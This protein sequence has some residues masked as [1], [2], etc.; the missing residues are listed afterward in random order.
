MQTVWVWGLTLVLC[1]SCSTQ[2]TLASILLQASETGCVDSGGVCVPQGSYC[3]EV[4]STQNDDCV[5]GSICCSVAPKLKRD[6]RDTTVNSGKQM[7]KKRRKHK[8][9][10]KKHHRQISKGKKTTITT[11]KK[12]KKKNKQPR[13]RRLGEKRK[14]TLTGL[15]KLKKLKKN[16]RNRL[17][18]SEKSRTEGAL[19]TNRNDDDK[20]GIKNKLN[21]AVYYK[22]SSCKA[23]AKCK[24]VGGKCQKNPCSGSERTV[25]S[26]C[27]GKGCYC[28]A[29]DDCSAITCNDNQL[30]VDGMCSCSPGYVEFDSRCIKRECQRNYDCKN[31]QIC[32]HGICYCEPGYMELFGICVPNIPGKVNKMS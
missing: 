14:K 18:A 9:S 10:K 4:L 28:C 3:N 5:N 1:W 20:E 26:G 24:K 30:C 6:V 21:V 19:K 22:G 31:N 32:Y 27:K 15:R 12:K 13:D 25:P 11:E 23:R 16:S 8:K 29:P 2:S 7:K 17:N